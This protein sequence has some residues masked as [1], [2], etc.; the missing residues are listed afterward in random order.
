MQRGRFLHNPDNGARKIE[1][2]LGV[3]PRHLCRLAAGQYHVMCPASPGDAFDNAQHHFGWQ[4]MAGDVIHEGDRA[5]AVDKNVIDRVIDEIFA[6]GV[7]APGLQRHEHLGAHAVCAHHERRGVHACR[8]PH[9]ATKRADVASRQCRARPGGQLSNPRFRRV[10]LLEVDASRSILRSAH[11]SRSAR[12]MW[13][14][15][16]NSRTRCSTASVVM[17][18]NPLIPK[19]DTE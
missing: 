3:Q 16:V 7:K 18:S 12:G 4:A 1:R 9:H 8:N 19:P 6:H 2:P 17:P 15:S 10:T 14:R 5:R 13:V 11:V